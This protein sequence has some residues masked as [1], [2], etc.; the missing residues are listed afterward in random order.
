MDGRR[1][2][3]IVIIAIGM[4]IFLFNIGG[5]DLWEPDETRYAVIAREMAESGNWILP[6]LNGEIYAEK[7]AL[8]FWLINLSTFFFGANNEFTNRFPSV[9][10]GL[11][12]LLITFLFGERL[13]NLRTGF[14]SSLILATCFLFPQ[15][16]RW[17]M[18]DS[19]FTLFFLL[20]LFYFYLGYEKEEGRRR[21]YY[22]AG[23]FMGL[24]I[25]IKGPVVYLA[26]PIFLIFAFFQKM[27]VSEGVVLHDASAMHECEDGA[28]QDENQQY[29]NFL[30]L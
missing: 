4:V 3:A 9:L 13:F 15:L 8:F 1:R 26:I 28:Y 7:P 12:T 6:H 16:S 22:L 21:Y 30:C 24:G 5:R 23:L 11:I 2:Y 18:L 10:A 17:M 14:L 27:L 19:L 29:K 25:L 20:A